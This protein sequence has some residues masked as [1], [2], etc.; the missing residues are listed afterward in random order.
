MGIKGEAED[1][2]TK[3]TFKRMALKNKMIIKEH[4]SVGLG[5]ETINYHILID[6]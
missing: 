5:N 2:Y 1:A 6:F 3:Y 4:C